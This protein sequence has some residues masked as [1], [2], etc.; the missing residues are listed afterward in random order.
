MAQNEHR[1]KATCTRVH[2]GDR[3]RRKFRLPGH[4]YTYMYVAKCVCVCVYIICGQ[5]SRACA[6]DS[7]SS[8][9]GAE[10]CALK[11]ELTLTTLLR[12]PYVCVI[13]HAVATKSPRVCIKAFQKFF[14]SSSR[15]WEKELEGAGDA[16]AGHDAD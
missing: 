13:I 12:S 2:L 16:V 15:R 8:G 5:H 11:I 1:L 3:P 14:N 10:N 6:L 7:V 9:S 4:A